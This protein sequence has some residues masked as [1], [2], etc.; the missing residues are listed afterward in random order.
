[1]LTVLIAPCT[2]PGLLYTIGMV[3]VT[4]VVGGIIA[5]RVSQNQGKGFWNGFGNYINENWAQTLA[6][7]MVTYIVTFGIT[8]SLGLGTKCFI[9][10]T[11]VLTSIGLVKIEDIK[12]DDEVWSYNEETKEKELKKVKQVFR[13]KTKEWLHL[14][15]VNEE[16][17]KEENKTCT[18]YHRIY[19]K[20]KGWIE[21]INILEN[22]LVL[23]YNNIQGRVISKEL[24][25]LDH[26]ETTYNFEVEDNHNYYVGEEC[27]LVHNECSRVDEFLNFKSEEDL[28]EHFT[29][30][31]DEFDDLYKTVDA[32]L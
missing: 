25:V 5:G 9:E 31:A 2:L 22:D 15:V 1:M 24:Q 12:P 13:N 20:N 8:Q 27:I 17:Q 29:K 7:E 16:T 3:G 32:Y 10:G 11:L 21:A 18:K 30:H 19:V 23:M 4:L 26:F 28:F 14:K 6:I